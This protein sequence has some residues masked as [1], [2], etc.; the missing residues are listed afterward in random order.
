MEGLAG[1]TV[2]AQSSGYVSGIDAGEVGRAVVELGAG[3]QRK[4]DPIDPQVGVVMKIEVGDRVERGTP[5]A[6]VY[7]RDREAS[8]RAAATVSQAVRLNEEPVAAK[9]VILERTMS[10]G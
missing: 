2:T 6:T 3:R 7:A 8:E 9:P 4:E 5:I 1:V 10:D